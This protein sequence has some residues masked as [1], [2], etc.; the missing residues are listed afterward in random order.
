MFDQLERHV[1][2]AEAVV[3]AQQADV[4]L[5]GVP[6]FDAHQR[7]QFVFLVGAL[8]IGDGKGHHHA[9][10]MSRGLLV[11]RVDQI[12]GMLGEMALIGCGS[13]QIEKKSAP[14]FPP[15]ALSRL[16]CPYVVGIRVA[17]IEVLSRKRCGVSACVSMIRAES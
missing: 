14:R 10:G 3:V 1:A 9:V 7:R 4:V 11:N 16:I 5:D 13:T 6:A 8:D 12:E 2:H 15:R 17:N